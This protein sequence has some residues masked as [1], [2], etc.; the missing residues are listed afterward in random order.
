MKEIQNPLYRYKKLIFIFIIVL[1]TVFVALSN[2][3]DFELAL[4][5]VFNTKIESI[6][7]LIIMTGLII[8]FDVNIL[9]YAI[10]DSK[11]TFPKALTINL[12]GSFFSGITPLYI[13]SYPSRVYY[14]Y[15]EDIP[16]DKTLSALTVK[17]FTFQIVTTTF[18]VIGLLLG[19]SSIINNGGYLIFLIIGFVYNFCLALFII[20][21]SSSKKINT[22]CVKLVDKIASKISGLNKRK[23][24][25]MNAITNYYDNTQRMYKDFKYF[26]RVLINTIFKVTITYSIPIVVFYGLGINVKESWP[27]I[28]A[29]ASLMQI[30]VSVFPTPG[31]LAASEAVFIILYGLMF[32]P[33]S[34][35]EAG[36]LIWRLF[37]YYIGIILGLIA[38]LYLQAKEPA[39]KSLKWRKEK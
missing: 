23:T 18:A 10:D 37:T 33:N 11:L 13:G 6:I 35:V 7:M 29:L 20:L 21:I 22:L 38:T 15:K 5:E 39:N 34:P 16:I 3:K 36:A 17:G 9:Y 8:F 25:I 1:L 12:A 24:E 32:K 28:F 27:Q 2:R 26:F 30:I 31:G 14:L 19:G 4:T